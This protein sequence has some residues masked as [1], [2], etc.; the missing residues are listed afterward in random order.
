MYM[1][2]EE[3]RKRQGLFWNVYFVGNAEKAPSVHQVFRGTFLCQLCQLRHLFRVCPVGRFQLKHRVS[4]LF[5]FILFF[6]VFYLIT[7]SSHHCCIE[8]C[9]HLICKHLTWEQSHVAYLIVVCTR[10][11]S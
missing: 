9:Q 6:I 5:L 3:G 2:D 8:V 7:S 1:V 4:T 11:S 10:A